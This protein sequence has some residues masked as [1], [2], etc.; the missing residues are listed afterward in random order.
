M[1]EMLMGYTGVRSVLYSQFNWLPPDETERLSQGSIAN[2]DAFTSGKHWVSEDA[3]S[4][5]HELSVFR[6]KKLVTV[7][8]TTSQI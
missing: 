4:V 2:Q 8:Q 6:Y 3:G 5:H 1:K 7:D